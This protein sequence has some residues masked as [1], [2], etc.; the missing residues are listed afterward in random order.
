MPAGQPTV[1]LLRRMREGDPLASEQLMTLVYSQLHQIA[2][3]RLRKERPNHTLQPTA[4]VSEAC[5][6]L[7]D[8]PRLEFTD[9][10]HFL[11]VASRIM[12][13]VL[14]DYARSR[15]AEKRGGANAGGVDTVSNLAAQTGDDTV[16]LLDLDAA[17]ASLAEEHPAAAQSIELLYFAGMTAEESAEA[18]GR[19]AHTIRHELRYARAWLKRRMQ[20]A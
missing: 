19:S 7:F 2:L 16:E 3:Q 20:T 1:Q 15:A 6:R 13:Q 5:L 11:A 14:V 8:F 10:A 9:R 4:L 12:R 17:I 18:T